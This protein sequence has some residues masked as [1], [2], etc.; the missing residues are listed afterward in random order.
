MQKYQV[1]LEGFMQN[2]HAQLRSHDCYSVE[3]A[4]LEAHTRKH[5]LYDQVEAWIAILFS[6]KEEA[7]KNGV[8]EHKIEKLS[9]TYRW[10]VRLL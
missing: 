10:I 2:Q 9:T 8:P 4:L 1:S 3:E 5:L 6:D 7:I